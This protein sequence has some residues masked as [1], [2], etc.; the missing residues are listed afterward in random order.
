MCYTY[1][2]ETELYSKTEQI[3]TKVY[4]RDAHKTKSKYTGVKINPE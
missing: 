3:S 2:Y 1:E 4:R